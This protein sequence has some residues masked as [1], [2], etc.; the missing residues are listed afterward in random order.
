M[1]AGKDD[2]AICWSFQGIERGPPLLA[3]HLIPH[4]SV[5][6]D[7]DGRVLEPDMELIIPLPDE[8]WR[9]NH[10]DDAWPQLRRFNV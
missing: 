4:S 2:L 5:L 1:G 8:P 7:L 9:E 6:G 10:D 3:L